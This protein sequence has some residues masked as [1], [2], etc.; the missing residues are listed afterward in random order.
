MFAEVDNFGRTNAEDA[1]DAYLKSPINA[2]TDPIKFWVSR[3]DKDGLKISPH[4][5]LARMGLDFLSAPG[6]DLVSLLYFPIA[7][8]M[9]YVATSTDVECL[10]SHGGMQ[11]TKRRHNLSF[12]TLRCLM[13]LCSWFEAG[14]VP[15]DRVLEYFRKLNGRR[16]DDDDSFGDD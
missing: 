10:F 8:V 5:A 7:Y 9:L 14:L 6:T 1:L 16:K 12:D 3:L 2:E 4:G 11:V 13:V 15:I